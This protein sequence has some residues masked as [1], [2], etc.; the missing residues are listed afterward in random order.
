MD[1]AVHAYASVH[2]CAAHARC[3]CAGTLFGMLTEEEGARAKSLLP[4]AQYFCFLA[5]SAPGVDSSPATSV[6]GLDP[7]LPPL[8]PGPGSHRYFCFGHMLRA[9]ERLLQTLV[10]AG[11]VSACG[12]AVRC[13]VECRCSQWRGAKGCTICHSQRHV[14]GRIRVSHATYDIVKHLTSF[15]AYVTLVKCDHSCSLVPAQMWQCC[16]RL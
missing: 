6:L 4:M 13:A 7:P 9:T 12:A 8:A 5:T 2:R 3:A 1:A 16:R 10:D 15:Y 11:A 14:A